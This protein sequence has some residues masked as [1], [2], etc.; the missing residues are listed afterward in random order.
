MESAVEFL[1]L[2]TRPERYD[3]LLSSVRV[4]RDEQEAGRRTRASGWAWIRRFGTHIGPAGGGGTCGSK[5]CAEVK[6]EPGSFGNVARDGRSAR[7]VVHGGLQRSRDL[8]HARRS[9]HGP[10]RQT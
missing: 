5:S 6:N 9:A 10:E 4:T 3:S 7:G 2:E 1:C 8:R